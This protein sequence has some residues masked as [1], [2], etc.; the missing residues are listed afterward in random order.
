MVLTIG[1]SVLFTSQY[2]VGKG[3]YIKFTFTCNSFWPLSFLFLNFLR[4]YCQKKKP[5]LKKKLNK[6]IP[7][8]SFRISLSNDSYTPVYF[9]STIRW[10]PPRG[11][12]IIIIII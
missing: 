8:G 6:K 12:I 5:N 7:I 10:Q 3:T 2:D 11:H 9:M 4:I 1:I